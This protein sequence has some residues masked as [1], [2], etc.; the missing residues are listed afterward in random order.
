MIPNLGSEIRRVNYDGAKCATL[1]MS[2]AKYTR[3]AQPRNIDSRSRPILEYGSSR[4][5]IGT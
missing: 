3:A 4:L 5:A 1:C 2:F